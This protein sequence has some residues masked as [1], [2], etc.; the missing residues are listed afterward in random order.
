MTEILIVVGIIG[1]VLALLLPVVSMS[2]QSAYAVKCLSK[3][4][5]FMQAIQT[6]AA[7]HDGMLPP[8]NWGNKYAGW[9]YN[10]NGRGPGSVGATSPAYFQESDLETGALYPYLKTHDTYRCTLDQTVYGSSTMQ[11]LTSF[12][13]NGAVCNYGANPNGAASGDSELQG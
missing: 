5:Q 13:M 9:L 2:R 12:M 11:V 4:Q 8:P 7:E 10:P 1:A 3:Q 6:Y